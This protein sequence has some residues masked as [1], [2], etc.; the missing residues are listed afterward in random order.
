MIKKRMKKNVGAQ[1]PWYLQRKI[2][3]ISL[4]SLIGLSSI[5]YNWEVRKIGIEARENEISLRDPGEPA[6]KPQ[7]NAPPEITSIKLSPSSPVK[8]DRIKAEVLAQDREGDNV[9]LSYQWA[10]DGKPLQETSDTLSTELKRGD[11]ISLTVTP[12]HGKEKGSATT[13][14]AYIFNAKPAI[15]SSIR[16]AK[17]E[18]GFTYQVRAED[19][20][21]DRPLYSL[22]SA[23]DGMTID[24]ETGL[25]RWDIPSSFK[26]KVYVVVSVIDGAGGEARQI[27][28]IQS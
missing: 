13:V 10:K 9:V 25:I 4:C 7:A 14:F 6:E 26:G 21:G 11:K 1:A 20:D 28:N 17:Y 19:P 8:G 27:F 2:L 12:V 3:F 16:D 24:H 5:A 23:P 18:N 15:T 22:K